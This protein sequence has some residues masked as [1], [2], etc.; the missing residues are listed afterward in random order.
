MIRLVI[1]FWLDLFSHRYIR[2]LDVTFKKIFCND[3]LIDGK[4]SQMILSLSF[5]RILVPSLSIYRNSNLK[6]KYFSQHQDPSSCSNCS[7]Q[8]SCTFVYMHK[9]EILLD[10]SCWNSNSNYLFCCWIGSF[11]DNVSLKNISLWEYAIS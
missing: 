1:S 3:F 5:H 10:I 4:W 11:A 6:E 2:T 8:W 9:C 7:P